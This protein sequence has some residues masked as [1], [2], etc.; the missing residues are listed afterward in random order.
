[1]LI[2]LL[3]ANPPQDMTGTPLIHQTF[4]HQVMGPSRQGICMTVSLFN[5]DLGP[6]LN[7]QQLWMLTT[8]PSQD[9]TGPLLIRQTFCQRVIGRS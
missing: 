3:A 5:T 8:N 2:G 7:L 1:M 4:Y 6:T 9:M